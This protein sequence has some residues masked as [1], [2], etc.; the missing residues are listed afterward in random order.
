[1][2]PGVFLELA[3]GNL[4][5]LDLSLQCHGRPEEELLLN[6]PERELL[7]KDPQEELALKGMPNSY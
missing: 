6:D 3:L 7:L 5:L 4:G 2:I 1:M